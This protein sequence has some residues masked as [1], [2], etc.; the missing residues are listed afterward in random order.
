MRASITAQS[1]RNDFA[2]VAFAEISRRLEGGT[3]RLIRLLCAMRRLSADQ[4]V[5]TIRIEKKKEPV[6]T[7]LTSASCIFAP[8]YRLVFD[9]ITQDF[10][11]VGLFYRRKR[12]GREGGGEFAR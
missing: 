3:V 4:N 11:L 8:Y 12:E 1:P 10:G 6:C 2:T 9:R 5:N 7:I